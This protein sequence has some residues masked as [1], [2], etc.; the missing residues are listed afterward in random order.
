MSIEMS[1]AVTEMSL[2]PVTLNRYFFY[3]NKDLNVIVQAINDRDHQGIRIAV[4]ANRIYILLSYGEDGVSVKGKVYRYDKHV[5][6]LVF[7]AT[8][9]EQRGHN[10]RT[11]IDLLELPLDEEQA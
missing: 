2:I 5:T 4:P 8:T 7:T 10:V 6:N 9:G 11:L 3:E 1:H